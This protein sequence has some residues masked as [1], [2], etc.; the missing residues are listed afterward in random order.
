MAG[1]V[2]PNVV[3]QKSRGCGTNPGGFPASRCARLT[4]ASC[5]CLQ[6]KAIESTT[7]SVTWKPVP[8]TKIKEFRAD[9]EL[10]WLV[11]HSLNYQPIE[12]DATRSTILG[13]VN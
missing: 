7:S 6:N 11:Q 9:A 12:N 13:Y 3:S 1:G 2:V 4:A 8:R 5:S 10:A